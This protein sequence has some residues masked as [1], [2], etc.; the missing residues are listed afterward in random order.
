MWIGG[1]CR[2]RRVSVAGQRRIWEPI[3]LGAGDLER[4][5]AIGRGPPAE[6]LAHP[7]APSIQGSRR[8]P[9]TPR[10]LLSCRPYGPGPGEQVDHTG[11]RSSAHPLS[12][13]WM[14][15]SFVSSCKIISRRLPCQELIARAFS[16]CSAP[17]LRER[18]HQTK[19]HLGCHP[20]GSRWHGARCPV[21][22]R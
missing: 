20:C 22:S 4:R 10:S 6:R 3:W 16:T 7:W 15:S 9:E 17:R 21:D 12:S 8:K 18:A 5:S 1:P 11:P 14:C 2:T 19:P 13:D